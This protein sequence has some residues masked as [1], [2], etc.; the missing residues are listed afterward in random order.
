MI[1]LRWVRGQSP[2]V[3]PNHRSKKWN[4]LVNTLFMLGGSI[5]SSG[6][7]SVLCFIS[8]VWC[9]S[10][11]S[12]SHIANKNFWINNTGFEISYWL[13]LTDNSFWLLQFYFK[14]TSIRRWKKSLSNL[15]IRFYHPCFPIR[16][17]RSMEV[18]ILWLNSQ[19]LILMNPLFVIICHPFIS[20]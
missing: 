19:T 1:G 3:Q 8:C 16:Q 20:L 15:N 13:N 14:V 11:L 18:M 10:T 6:W 9:N 4:K 12:F 2:R 7:L 17:L 5:K